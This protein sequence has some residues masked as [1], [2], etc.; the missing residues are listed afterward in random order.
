MSSMNTNER[1]VPLLPLRGVLVYPTMVLH[2]DVGRDKSIQALEQAAMDENIIFLAMQKEMNIDDPKEDDIYSVG[3]VAKVKQML[4]LPNGTL[5]VLVEGLHRAE[6]IEFIEEENV[7]QVSIKT[8]T[9][10][11]EFKDVPKPVEIREILDEYVIG[12]DS[13]KKALAVAVYNHYKR[14]NSNSKIDDVELAKS[15]IALIGPTGSG[16][17]LLAQTLARILNVPFAIADAT[18]LTEAGYVGEDVENILLKLIQA[19]DYDVEKAEKGIIYIDEIDKVARKSENPSITRDVSGEG[20]Q[21]ALLKILEG[22]VASVPPQGGRKHPHQEFIQIDT[23]NILFICGGA[24]DGIEPIIKRR[25]GEKVIGFGSEKKNAD[26]NE[27]HVLSHVLP[28]DLLRFGLIPE[29]IGRLPVIANLEPLDEDALVD[30]LTKPKNALVKQFQKLLELDDVELEFEEGALI[31]IAKKAIERKTGA[32]GL[33]SIIEGLML[34]VMFE[35]PSRKDIEKCI[36]TKETVADN[37][38]P[39]LVLQ[40]GTVLDTKTSA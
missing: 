13:A 24:F 19:A 32:R 12:Q 37:E 17:T 33:R 4:K 23:T 25:L 5:R 15:N 8:V 29:F 3:T 38:P 21:Q 28:E 26:V 22:T 14:I 2:L 11:V 16:K 35:L 36:L 34:D 6:V 7:V 27:K 18:S 20:V 10:E 1:I 39:K 9:E 40:D 31:E 30:I